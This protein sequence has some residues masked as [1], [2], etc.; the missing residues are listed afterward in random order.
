AVV[1]VGNCESETAREL[2]GLWLGSLAER[3]A[4]NI[5]LLPGR[6]KK[7]IA[8]VAFFV[9]R[10]VEAPAPAGQSARGNI[11]T[12]REH[13]GAQLT[14][15]DQQVVEL[16]RHVALDARNRRL[17]MDITLRKTVDHGLLKARLV[18]EDVVRNA[19][20]LRDTAGVVDILTRATGAFAMHSCAMVVELQRHADHVVALRLEQGC[21]H[22]R[23]DATGHG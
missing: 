20:A 14:R 11:V 5:K 7:E 16:D 13:I 4:Q 2:T 9:A 6:A 19:D 8:L 15:R 21:R 10:A 17:P 3:E 18:I 12:G 1:L 23:V 22:R